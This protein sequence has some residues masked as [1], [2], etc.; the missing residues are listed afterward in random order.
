MLAN[1]GYFVVEGNSFK[2][3]FYFHNVALLLARY[4]GTLI[5][6]GLSD[7]NFDWPMSGRCMSI[8]LRTYPELSFST[9]L[10]M[11]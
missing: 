10:L 8:N 2:Y 1:E 4:S 3:Q 5:Q 11:K 6:I 7:R 9:K